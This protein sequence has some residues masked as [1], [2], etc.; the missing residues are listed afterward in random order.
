MVGILGLKKSM[1]LDGELRKG[2]AS[3]PGEKSIQGFL[4][5]NKK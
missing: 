5:I 4:A 3:L 1:G 2:T